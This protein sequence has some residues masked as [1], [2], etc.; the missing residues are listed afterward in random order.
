MALMKCD[1]CE[2]DISPTAHICVHCG[3]ELRMRNSLNGGSVFWAM[4]FAHIISVGI[5]VLIFR[6]FGDDIF[7]MLF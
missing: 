2:N 4:L 6:F 7:G 5:L 1:D 3:R